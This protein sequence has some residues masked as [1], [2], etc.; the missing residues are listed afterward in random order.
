[1]R[2]MTERTHIRALSGDVAVLA[3]AT[4]G[5]AVFSALCLSRPVRTTQTV[6]F[7]D[8]QGIDVAT[9]SFLREAILAY[10][11]HCRAT[12]PAIYP[13]LANLSEAVEEELR[14]LLVQRSDAM[15]HCQLSK[16]G[17]VSRAR[18]VGA[19][20]SK[21]AEALR[22]V[23]EAGPIDAPSLARR[24]DG[25][26]KVSATAWNNRLSALARKSLVL[27]TSQGRSVLFQPV[28][29]DLVYGT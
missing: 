7:L 3:G 16:T 28:L 18:V 24:Q 8:L 5:A 17:T 23:I 9:A 27:S 6:Q 10:R 12:F 2:Y 22:L 20:E 26:G 25:P 1:M 19:L 11:D 29:K 15:A 4:L 13:V 14:N 21:Q